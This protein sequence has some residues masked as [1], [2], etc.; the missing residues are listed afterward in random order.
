MAKQTF[1]LAALGVQF[2]LF[3]AARLRWGGFPLT[4]AD[5]AVQLAA[6]LGVALLVGLPC[7]LVTAIAA[8]ILERR[9]ASA[10]PAG[11][12]LRRWLAGVPFFWTLFVL[13]GVIVNVRYLPAM[14]SPLSL[15][16]DLLLLLGVVAAAIAWRRR[17][18]GR[19]VDRALA[20]GVLAANLLVALWAWGGPPAGLAAG[21]P[22]GVPPPG[23]APDVLLVLIDT[24]RADHL[25]AYGY[26]R[27]TSPRMDELAAAGTVFERAYS[28]SNWTRP[29]VASLFSSAMPSRH[30]ANEIDRAVSR[31]L[32]LL[33]EA[34]TQRGYEVGFFTR[35][36]NVEPA[37]GYGRGVGTFYHRRSRSTLDRSVLPRYLGAGI[38]PGIER[39]REGGDG[40]IDPTGPRT[41]TDTALSWLGEA[42]RRRPVFMYVHYMG[43]HRPYAAP[44]PFDRAFSAVPPVPELMSPP[45]PWAGPEALSDADR[46]QMIA[47]YDGEILWHDA[48][49][50]RLVEGL[51]R[52]GRRRG[53]VVMITSDHG[54]AFGEHGMWGHNAGLFEEQVR[55][56]LIVWAS[57][58]WDSP[59]R[60]AVPVSLLDLAPTLM[61]IAGAPVP[62]SFD[63]GSLLDWLKGGVPPADRT[64]FME[65]PRHDELGVRTAEW[66]YFEGRSPLGDGPW[67]Y[68]AD[69]LRQENNLAAELPEKVAELRELVVERRR[70]DS[71]RAGSSTTVELTEE[72]R[73][74]LRALG[75]ID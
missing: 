69:D 28:N 27:D 15:L 50:G 74:R 52:A 35:G 19:S 40:E 11:G 38:L 20:T 65:N 29:S 44:A 9:S 61:E 31:D 72:R 58:G 51:G 16:G 10:S 13:L 4:A 56:P 41:L 62:A 5:L 12:G 21:R 63:G 32:P 60:L 33:A 68:R 46:E 8:R 57:L 30:G 37:D 54:E 73:E 55:V 18:W 36:G 14:L 43:P 59:R 6:H 53:S 23:N 24:L 34:M 22:T 2:G 67:L 7:L 26:P 48:E 45:D 1:L 49:V 3:E 39:A 25:G 66:A 70:I 47:Q 64:V 17:R 71:Q 75:Y 42:D